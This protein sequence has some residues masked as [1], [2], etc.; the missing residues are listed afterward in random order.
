MYD[1]EK[2]GGGHDTLEGVDTFF[3]E[4]RTAEKWFPY[5]IIPSGYKLEIKKEEG[6]YNHDI[7]IREEDQSKRQGE[8]EIVHVE[9]VNLVEGESYRN[10]E[11]GAN[12]QIEED[13][14]GISPLLKDLK[15]SK[16]RVVGVEVDPNAFAPKID[17]ARGILR[18]DKSMSVLYLN[19]V[20]NYVH[21]Q[22]NCSCILEVDYVQ[23]KDNVSLIIQDILVHE[24]RLVFK[25]P[26][27][28]RI[29]CMSR[30]WLCGS[31]DIYFQKYTCMDQMYVNQRY[32]ESCGI[33]TDG[34]ICVDKN[35][36]YGKHASKW[37]E[38][39]TINCLVRVDVHGARAVIRDATMLE[40]KILTALDNISYRYKNNEVCEF[41]LIGLNLE[42][43]RHRFDENTSTTLDGYQ[44]VLF[45]NSRSESVKVKYRIISQLSS[46][47]Q[48]PHDSYDRYVR[49]KS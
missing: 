21:V 31:F 12:T 10:I 22:S 34:V 8:R 4:F 13:Y 2:L 46:S 48:R 23:S 7:H 15:L 1:K 41:K 40:D 39:E 18:I 19:G 20:S 5:R 36:S 11:V 26:M 14:S 47:F 3:A 44:S 16:M 42:Y 45:F 27:Y 17:G 35:K 38:Y 6:E 43:V 24:S 32:Y 28:Q 29:R 30:I 37:K 33:R 49:K 9:K 25:D